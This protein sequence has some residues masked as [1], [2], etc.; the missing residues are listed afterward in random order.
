[1]LCGQNSLLR[2]DSLGDIAFTNSKSPGHSDS[3]QQVNDVNYSRPGEY[4]INV[5]LDP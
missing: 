5:G 2:I 3:L 4:S 1:M